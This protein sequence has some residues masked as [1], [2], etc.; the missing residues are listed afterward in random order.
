MTNE[1]SEPPEYFARLND[2]RSFPD[3]ADGRVYPSMAAILWSAG[4]SI[5]DAE[6][7]SRMLR[8]QGYYL[9][10]PEKLGW[11]EIKAFNAE[12]HRGQSIFE[13]AGGYFIRCILALFGIKKP[14][15]KVVSYQDA[16]KALL[17][18]SE[19]K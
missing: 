14:D 10:N 19:A 9:V 12:L 17:T 2:G 5:E 13:D 16:V 3:A 6:F 11:S 7:A 4:L 8:S 18:E 1:Y 15:A